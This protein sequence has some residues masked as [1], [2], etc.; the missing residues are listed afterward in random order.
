MGTCD[1]DAELGVWRSNQVP[2]QLPCPLYVVGY[3]SLLFRPGEILTACPVYDAEIQLKTRQFAQR[4]TDHRGRP[5]Y[6]GLVVTLVG[7]ARGESCH[8]RVWLVSP[9]HTDATLA[10]LDYRERGGYSR[11]IVRVKLLQSTPHHT[12]GDIVEALVY[13]GAESNP[14]Y[15]SLSVERSGSIIACAHGVS[16]ANADY[17][18]ALEDFLVAQKIEDGYMRFLRSEVERRLPFH[19]LRRY[20]SGC[21]PTPP[22]QSTAARFA[23]SLLGWGS[24]EH[25]QLAREAGEAACHPL[26][27]VLSTVA[28]VIASFLQADTAAF[29]EALGAGLA[30]GTARALAG[31]ACSGLLLQAQLPGASSSNLLFL[32]G[33]LAC[34]PTEHPA[35]TVLEKG[36][37]VVQGVLDAA[38][39]HDA[40]LLLMEGGQVWQL[41]NHADADGE[42]LPSFVGREWAS[43]GRC[44]EDVLKVQAGPA[45]FAA[46]TKRGLFAWGSGSAALAG[47]LPP[48]VHE[49]GHD[50]EST[51]ALVDVCCGFNYT[52]VVDE[53][54]EVY[55][56]GKVKNKFGELGRSSAALTAGDAALPQKVDLPAAWSDGSSR[57]KWHKL[58]SGWHH[59]VLSGV[60]TDGAAMHCAWGRH[61]LGQYP[62][63]HYQAEGVHPVL[64]P[65]PP[66][67]SSI[68]SLWAGSEFTVAADDAGGLWASGWNEHG[69]LGAGDF[70]DSSGSAWVPVSITPS[71]GLP[72]DAL[73]ACGGAHVLLCAGDN[74]CT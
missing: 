71:V 19:R 10:Y 5:A 43:G 64:L 38:L 7:S 15:L 36:V 49:P 24:D 39:G 54:G 34:V 44:D 22:R 55:S 67:V 40:L 28:S 37:R 52:V 8:G 31:G 35:V 18:F 59:V 26:P 53:L 51:I 17:L 11:E 47:W 3:G 62:R 63:P 6:P 25:G 68:H 61:D 60:R 57:I 9:E 29:G 42:Q 70:A 58:A 50:H 16:G 20:L 12:V 2:G 33:Q 1:W 66:D 45:H 41:D 72:R 74:R 48:P 30:Q 65:L 69:N 27:A 14:N 73:L 13:T 56:V 32:W 4:S 23:C 21:S 46:I